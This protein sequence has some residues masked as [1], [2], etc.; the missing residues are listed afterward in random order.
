MSVVAARPFDS[1]TRAPSEGTCPSGV[2]TV[3]TPDSVKV[4]GAGGGTGGAVGDVGLLPSPPHAHIEAARLTA[5]VSRF[6]VILQARV[7]SARVR[8]L[9]FSA[10]EPGSARV[11][12]LSTIKAAHPAYAREC[13]TL[14]LRASVLQ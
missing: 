2:T 9:G 5:I 10:L 3:P 4:R 14:P 11:R 8:S 7:K 6:I 12:V 1:S 13:L